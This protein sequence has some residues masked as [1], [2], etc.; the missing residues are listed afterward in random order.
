MK[1]LVDKDTLLE[2]RKGDYLESGDEGDCYFLDEKTVVKIYYCL[3]K[4]RHVY[5]DDMYHEQIAYPI[6]ILIDKESKLIAGYTMPYLAGEKI[7]DSLDKFITIDDLRDAYTDLLEVFKEQ[8]HIYAKD[9]C[10]ENMLYDPKEKRINI[11]DTSRWYERWRGHKDSM[12]EFNMY[13]VNALLKTFDYYND[14]IKKTK[15]LQSLYDLYEYYC[16]GYGIDLIKEAL[17]S[18]L[19]CLVTLFGDMLEEVETVVSEYKGYK[20]KTIKDIKV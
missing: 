8:E 3:D 13:M 9:N 16:S 1:V 15:R 18:E 2:M 7:S 20:V 11:I 4:Y 6:D 10:L 14:K 17:T 12:C 5:F 19:D